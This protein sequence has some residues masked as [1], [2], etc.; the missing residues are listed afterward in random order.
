MTH[1]IPASRARIKRLPARSMADA[2]F[3]YR[4][5]HI[6]ITR[7]P[8]PYGLRATLV[9]YRRADGGFV[10][11]REAVCSDLRPLIAEID[12]HLDARAAEIRKLATEV[13]FA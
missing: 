11:T 3:V 7:S 8:E 5:V 6:F 10:H 12:A 4:N 2:V 1:T 13:R 9:G